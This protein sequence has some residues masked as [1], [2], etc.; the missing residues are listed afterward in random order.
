MTD[1][2]RL[3][4][5]QA[6]YYDD[7]KRLR[8]QR[9]RLLELLLDGK[10]HPNHECASVGGLSFNDSIFCFREEGWQIDSR[11]VR[12]GHWEYR[13]LGK[14]TPRDTHKPMTRPQRLVATAYM[15]AIQESCGS[16]AKQAVLAAVPTWMRPI[17][18]P[19][20]AGAE[21]ARS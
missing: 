1:F 3:T 18:L 11:H 2:A 13:L 9:G 8:G 7:L 4:E 12:G 17:A 15:T 5:A 16:E 14:T 21:V 6:Q 20:R 19:L 10:W